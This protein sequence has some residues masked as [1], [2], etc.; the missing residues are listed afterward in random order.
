MGVDRPRVTPCRSGLC[1]KEVLATETRDVGEAVSRSW[2][3]SKRE[4]VGKERRI[5]DPVGG[6]G[7]S[8]RVALSG[9]LSRRCGWRRRR[10]ASRGAAPG[11]PKGDPEQA[12]AA[13]QRL[14]DILP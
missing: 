7:L 13:S 9:D 6:G 4:G 3:P 1:Y 14:C 2:C 12:S 11:F 8:P 10:E 5:G